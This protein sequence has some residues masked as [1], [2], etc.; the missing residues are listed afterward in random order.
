[1]QTLH[2]R[3][4]RH[5]P[6]T[7]DPAKAVCV[8]TS[9]VSTNSPSVDDLPRGLTVS[10]LSPPRPSPTAPKCGIHRGFVSRTG[11]Q[12]PERGRPHIDQSDHRPLNYELKVEDSHCALQWRRL[13]PKRVDSRWGPPPWTD[14]VPSSPQ[15]VFCPDYPRGRPRRKGHVAPVRTQSSALR[16]HSRTSGR[17]GTHKPSTCCYPSLYGSSRCGVLERDPQS[18]SLPT[19]HPTS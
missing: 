17:Q 18:E 14:T 8:S 15:Q 4:T 16:L 19:T 5:P 10:V 2:P 7:P 12:K 11:Q 9:D 13:C 3:P 6:R 1:M